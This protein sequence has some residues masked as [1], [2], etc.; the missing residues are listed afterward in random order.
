MISI[1]REALLA[2]AGAAEHACP[3]EACGLLVGV[4]GDVFEAVETANL[5]DRP[6]RFLIDP[7]AHIALMRRLRGSG[8]EIVGVFHSHPEGRAEPSA[9][10][11]EAACYPGWLWLIAAPRRDRGTEIAAFRHDAP[12]RF[13]PLGVLS[14][15]APSAA[16]AEEFGIAADRGRVDGAHALGR[17]AQEIMRPARFRPCAGQSAAAEGLHADDG[18][19]HVAIDIDIARP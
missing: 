12:G 10:D 11:R 4:G 3:R 16:E 17:E 13:T 18:A 19:D 15:P 7:R 9:I 5:A 6:D 2:I 8:L 14:P 1:A